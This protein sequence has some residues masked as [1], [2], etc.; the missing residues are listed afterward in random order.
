MSN[1]TTGLLVIACLVMLAFGKTEGKHFTFKQKYQYEKPIDWAED[2]TVS[3]SRQ[4]YYEYVYTKEI[5][6]YKR[7][8][9]N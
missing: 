1:L 5:E 2:S 8:G 3:E 4:E 9:L 7:K 6:D